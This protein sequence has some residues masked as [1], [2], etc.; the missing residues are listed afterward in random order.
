MKNNLITQMIYRIVLCCVSG[1][2]VLLSLSFFSVH[3][4]PVF[5]FGAD[6]GVG[7]SFLKYYTNISNYFVFAVSVAVLI[8][9]VRHVRKGE[10]TGHNRVWRNFK[11]MTTVMISVTFLVVLILLD[12]PT[13]ISFWNSLGNM[14]YHVAA[15][16]LF[17]LDFFLFD[18]HGAVSWKLPLLSLVIPLC[19]VFYILVLGSVIDNF[20]YPYFFLNVHELGY[21]GVALWVAVLLAAFTAL[22]YL[23]WLYDKLEKREGKWKIVFRE[24]AVRNPSDTEEV[25]IP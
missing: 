4:S 20:E 21:G 10:T 12:N 22:G 25:K 13:R 1:L 16:V 6:G 24:S 8:D 11:F 3:G 14:T 17:I 18:E 5:T 7:W 19:Y 15:P 23:Y 9:N 2:A